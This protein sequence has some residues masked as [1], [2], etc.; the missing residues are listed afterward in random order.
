MTPGRSTASRSLVRTVAS[1]PI[2][3]ICAHTQPSAN[4]PATPSSKITDSTA[5]AVGSIS[6]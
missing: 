1:T 3:P 2:V 6:A 5:S 4:A